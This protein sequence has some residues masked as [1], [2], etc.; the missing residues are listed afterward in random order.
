MP[1]HEPPPTFS[2]LS[3]DDIATCIHAEPG[4]IGGSDFNLLF[5]ALPSGV[6]DD[7]RRRALRLS[8]DSEGTWRDIELRWVWGGR[9]DWQVVYGIRM[10]GEELGKMKDRNEPHRK[11]RIVNIERG[12]H[13]VR[14]VLPREVQSGA[15]KKGT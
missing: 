8:G 14:P 6:F 2:T 7:L 9:S 4:E 1:L 10:L 12:N 13:F 15:D 11:I 5:S 3:P